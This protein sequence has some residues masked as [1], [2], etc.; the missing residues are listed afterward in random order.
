VF[1]T[2]ERLSLPFSYLKYLYLIPQLPNRLLFLIEFAPMKEPATKKAIKKFI[3]HLHPLKIDKRAIAFN[4]TFGLG[5]IAAL[6]FTLLFITGM[7]LKFV[8]V[9]SAAQAHDSILS[10]K[11]DIIL[12]I[13][14]EIFTIGA[15]CCL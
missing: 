11:N 7:M 5:G 15:P 2:F 6:L 13:C 1:Y 12:E 9:P 8:Y 3:L 4:R 14:F 10:L